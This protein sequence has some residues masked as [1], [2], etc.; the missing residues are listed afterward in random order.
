MV[1]PTRNWCTTRPLSVASTLFVATI[2]AVGAAVPGPAESAVA[3]PTEPAKL[4]VTV[5]PQT[6]S[7]GGE[8][9][10]TVR[11][12][13]GP[14]IKINR[15]PKMKLQVAAQAGLVAAAEAAVGSKELPPLDKPEANYYKSVDPVAL[16]F[17]LDPKVSPGLHQIPA[18]FTYYYCVAASG[19]CA[20]K[21]TTIE[22]PVTVR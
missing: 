3:P 9:E 8:V 2:M 20:P 15:Y 10:V 11:L 5:A 17:V 12:A 21:P 14:G 22:I 1:H 16:K 6:V 18:K 13:P 4:H 7:P 19:F